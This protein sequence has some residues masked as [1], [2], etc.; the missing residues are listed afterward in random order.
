MKL[1]IISPTK[2]I[3][4]SCDN[5]E[6]NSLRKQLTYTNTST[7]H[8]IKRHY[9]N[10]FWKSRN[11]ITWQSH[12][13]ELQKNL[14]NTLVFDDNGQLYIR[15]G[16]IPYI[17]GID[18]EI[19][20]NVVYPA[21][22]KIPLKNPI[23]FELHPYQKESIK[24][25]IEEKHG[26]VSLTT[27]SGKTIIV[28]KLCQELG[29]RTCVVAPGKGIFNELVEKFE[30]HFGKKHVGTF[31][32]GK[33]KIDKLFT[34]CIGDS[35]ANIKPDSP[36]Y[37]F[38]SNLDVLIVDESHT[39][40]S[41]SLETICHGV[42]SNIPYRFFLSATQTRNDGT[43]PLLQ[44]IIGKTVHELSTK[45]AIEKGYICNHEFRIISL[46]SSN[47][48]FD[49][50][51][52]LAQKRV[53]FLNNTNIAKFIAKLANAMATSQGKQT[54]VLCEELTQL[55]M[56]APLLTVPYALAHSE[57]RAARL[58]ELGL[59]KVDV[60]E[61]IERFNKNEVKVLITTSCCHVGVNLYPTHSTC[62]WIGGSSEIKTKQAT[63]GRSVRHGKSNPWAS[64]CVDKDK[65]ILYDFD[66]T[67]N[68]TMKRHLDARIECYK[69]SGTEIRFIKLK[70]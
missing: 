62:G 1:K 5:S 28:L 6:L 37:E 16:S 53:H 57:K 17:S 31:G 66:V 21:P 42:L 38:F 46:E 18:L 65:A 11:L 56:L 25:L 7:Q 3:I 4:D 47:P 43:I 34:I 26:N 15:P 69:D 68:P 61:S 59:T 12:L 13:E 24:K 39:F 2:A 40:G 50:S 55:A 49:S 32:D 63:V 10:Y 23:P 44:S 45:E 70:S 19:E 27:G 29:L 48:S 64:K 41:E 22:K 30:H 8:L 20:N 14:K 60:E 9:N 67:N 52:A 33:K 36:E 51:D 54:L 35:I 58:E